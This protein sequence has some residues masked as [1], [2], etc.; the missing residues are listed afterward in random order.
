MRVCCC[1]KTRFKTRRTADVTWQA[2]SNPAWP[3][4]QPSL[5]ALGRA[6]GAPP[7]RPAARNASARERARTNGIRRHAHTGPVRLGARN[8]PPPCARTRGTRPAPRACACG[9]P[10][11]WGE[12][13]CRGN[14]CGDVFVVFCCAVFGG[15][16]RVALFGY[17]YGAWRA[18]GHWTSKSSIKHFGLVTLGP[19][20]TFGSC[21]V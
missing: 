10:G 17:R 1:S 18:F 19:K 5:A 11:I 9:K 13:P 6:A 7:R 14:C 16:F 3:K 15:C 20:S 21:H 4:P 12:P 8:A 2:A